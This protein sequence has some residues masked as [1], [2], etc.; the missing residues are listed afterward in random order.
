MK[1]RFLI[2]G[3]FALAIARAGSA[4]LVGASAALRTGVPAAQDSSADDLCREGGWRSW[5]DYDH[6]CEVRE[7]RLPAGPLTVDA[8]SN[9]G[10]RVQAWDRNEILVRAV[11]HAG[12]R[13]E[14]EAKQI[15]SEVNVRIADGRVSASGPE[16]YRRSWWSVSYRISVPRRTDLDLSARNGGI[17]VEGVTGTLTLGTT[18]GGVSLTDVGGRVRGRTRNGGVR[19][20]LSGQR[21]DGEG[22]DA[23]TTNGGVTVELPEGYNA[24]LEA[25]T[26]NGGFRSDFPLTVQGNLSPRYGLSSTLGSGGPTLRLRTRN[27]GVRIQRR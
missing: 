17:S 1:L 2:V 18:N 3:V 10:I 26:V 15:A 11:V 21:W 24:Q 14:E 5:D 27:G 25:S 12:A 19:V 13:T 6:H 23:E 9:G 8:G 7:E 20:K 4:G 22:L 16:R